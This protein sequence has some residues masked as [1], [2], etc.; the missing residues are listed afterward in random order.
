MKIWIDFINSPQVSF[1]DALVRE[2]IIDGH[3][4]ILTCRDS[5]NTVDLLKQR[6]FSYTIV[7][8]SVRRSTLRKLINFPMRIYSLLVFLKGKKI[9]VAICQ[10]SFY[11]PLTATLL[12]IPSIYTNDNEHALGNIPAFLFASKIFIPEA[13]DIL[14]IIKKGAKRSKILVYPG[15]KEGVYLWERGFDILNKIILIHED[16]RKIYIRPEPHTA[17]YYSGKLNFL[18][19]LILELKKKYLVTILIRE[20]SQLEHYTQKQFIGIEVPEHPLPF[21]KIAH[22]CLVFI[23]AGGSMTRE[24]A[25]IGIP[26]ISVYQGTLLDVDKFLL[27]KKMMTHHLN[28]RFIDIEYMLASKANSPSNISLLNKGKEAYQLFKR[29]VL[30]YKQ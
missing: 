16:D 22:T 30:K 7:G 21:Q 12:K 14:K 2:F 9:D 23:G 1:F 4:V 27:D 5:A 24:M 3:E 29:E 28:L 8:A 20:K 26:T 11:L 19:D 25:L 10:S 6:N 13:V 17:Q 18:D 15:I